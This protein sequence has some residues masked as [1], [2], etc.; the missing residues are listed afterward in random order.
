MNETHSYKHHHLPVKKIEW[1]KNVDLLQIISVDEAKTLVV[2]D[3]ILNKM[4]G[5]I[6]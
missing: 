4:V 6:K 1:H 5:Q 3:Y 2:F